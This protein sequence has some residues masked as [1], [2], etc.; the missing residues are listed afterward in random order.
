MRAVLR[1]FNHRFDEARADLEAVVAGDPSNGQA[2]SWLAAIA[3]VQARYA[4]ARQACDHMSKLASRLI[5]AACKAQVDSMTG[6]AKPAAASLRAALQS[7]DDASPAEKLWALTRLAEIDERLGDTAA[8]ARSF[9]RA[10]GLD[11][12]DGY[13]L[14]A[15]ADFLLDQRQH[16]AVLELLK[17]RQRSDLL[18]L[19]LALAAKGLGSPAL[20]GWTSELAARFDAARMRGDNVHQ[21]EESRFA[22]QILAQPAR[23]LQLAQANFEIQRE[24]ADARLLLEA[25]LAARAPQA[26][27]PALRWLARNGVESVALR[28]LEHRI[29]FGS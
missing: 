10:L 18:L 28:A 12:A 24:P 3:M 19:R 26:A 5:A 16:E 6:S 17:G 13:L 11:I 7:S 21:K 23:A 4:D 27:E 20:A 29:R 25:A 14:A 9:Q 1:Q 22:L 2:W 15:Y 8:A